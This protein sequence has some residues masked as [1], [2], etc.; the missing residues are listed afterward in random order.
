MALKERFPWVRVSA[1]VTLVVVVTVAGLRLPDFERAPESKTVLPK[2]GLTQIGPDASAELL[3]EQLAAYDP[4]PMFIPSP[5]TSSDPGIKEDVQGGTGGPFEPLAPDLTK[6]GPLRFAAPVPVPAGPVEGLRLTE[7]TEA[8]LA[9]GRADVAGEGLFVRVGQIEAISV[10]SGR[11][12][13][14]HTMPEAPDMPDGDWQ[15]LELMGAITRAGLV[16]ELVVTSSSGSE[17]MDDFF[18]FHLRKNVR[19]DARLRPGFYA[20]RVGP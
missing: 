8:A 6:N 15:P 13:F 18:R 16:G 20:F 9:L 2:V 14:T 12:V 7:R 5:M 1:V 10:D 19:I 17:E 11:V 4:T 3:A